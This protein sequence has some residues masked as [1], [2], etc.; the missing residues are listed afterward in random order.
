MKWRSILTS[1]PDTTANDDRRVVQLHNDDAPPPAMQRLW[2][3]IIAYSQ[4]V[5]RMEADR[6]TAEAELAG[7][8]NEARA[9]I[10]TLD[11]AIAEERQRLREAKE[12]WG[13]MTAPL[14]LGLD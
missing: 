2:R 12:R 10:G 11:L 1:I 3:E 4:A 9:A 6:V 5:E 14:R 8:I 13:I 7:M